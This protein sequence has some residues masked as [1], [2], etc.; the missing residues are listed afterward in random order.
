VNEQRLKYESNHQINLTASV[1]SAPWRQV[2]WGVKFKTGIKQRKGMDENA[3][4]RN[5]QYYVLGCKAYDASEFQKALVL[6]KHALEYW[7]EDPQAW[8]AMENGYDELKRPWRAESAFRNALQY[9]DEKDKEGILFNLGNSLF[10]QQRYREAIALYNILRPGS[11]RWCLAQRN[12]ELA[13]AKR[14]I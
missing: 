10:D 7:P 6:F 4:E 13:K 2:I 12:I 8:M 9:S 11:Q 14:R 3:E 1:A 5:H